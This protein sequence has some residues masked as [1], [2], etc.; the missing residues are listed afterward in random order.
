MSLFEYLS[1][2][3]GFLSMLAAIYFIFYGIQTRTPTVVPVIPGLEIYGIKFPIFEVII[4]IFI[5][6]FIHELFHALLAIRNNIK[7]KSFGIF[8]FGPF[9]GAFVEPSDDIFQIN[10][11]KQ[12]SI[13]NAGIL[14]NIL[15]SLFIIV[16]FYFLGEYTNVF[17]QETYVYI[18]G[19]VP[20]VTNLENITFSTNEKLLY[21]GNTEIRNIR[22][23]EEALKSYSPGDNIE[24][25][26]E[27]NIYNIKLSEKEGK[28]FIGLYF[29]QE[30]KFN[31]FYNILFWILII[32]LGIALGNSL[33]IFT[34]DGGQ[35]LKALLS[36]IVKDN[37][38]V[39]ILHT[40][41]S[42]LI[43]IALFSNIFLLL[44]K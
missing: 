13:F 20:N 8:F 28:P 1:I 43:L 30:V 15:L 19:K 32:S 34:L 41:I 17:N 37:R 22:D 36:I 38:K 10:K 44:R 27:K 6:A 11:I 3:I 29:K 31:M 4:A 12:I 35:A 14:A 5:S 18:V 21:I 16:F 9:L 26:T 40:L 7:I 42:Y 2:P 33:P 23:I 24:I 25:I 39:S